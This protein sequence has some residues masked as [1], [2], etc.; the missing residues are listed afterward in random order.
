MIY[1]QEQKHLINYKV[2]YDYFLDKIKENFKE[3]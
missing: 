1:F 3:L 2:F